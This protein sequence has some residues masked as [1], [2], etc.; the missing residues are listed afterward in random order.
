M[1]ININLLPWRE[2]RRE[3]RTRQFYGVMLFMLLAGVAGGFAVL[4]VYQQQL[5]VQQQRNNHISAHIEQL[6]NQIDDVR[7]YQGD[8]EQL[9]EQLALFHT[10]NNERMST[11]RLF[12][13]IAAS[14]ADGVVY[15]RLSRSGQ[16]VSLS[17]VASNERQISDQLRQIA[18]MPGLGVPLFSEVA[19]SQDDSRRVFQFEVMQ[20]SPDEAVSMETTP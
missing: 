15:Q 2:A 13:D 3:R 17:A 11:V 4:H 10:L 5:A 6:D 12:N 18:D 14:V 9:G 1:S 8:T 20:L 16:R 19:S 7:R